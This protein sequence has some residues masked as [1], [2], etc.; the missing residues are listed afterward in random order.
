M[1]G[2]AP[3]REERTLIGGA[4]VLDFDLELQAANGRRNPGTPPAAGF[5]TVDVKEQDDSQALMAQ[6][7]EAVVAAPTT[8]PWAATMSMK[9]SW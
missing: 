2:F 7:L 3:A 1:F 5:Q 6:Q 8:Q 9:P 4:S